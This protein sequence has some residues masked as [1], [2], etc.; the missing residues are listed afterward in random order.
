MRMSMRRLATVSLMAVSALS[1]ETA[2]AGDWARFRG[3][4]GSGVSA[5]EAAIPA[6]WSDSK[7]LQWKAE[8][9]GPGSSSPIVVGDRVFVTSWSG[10]ADNSGDEGSLDSLQRHLVCI[11]RKTGRQLW[12]STV[13]A[14][15][16]EETYR[17][18]FAEN[19]YKIFLSWC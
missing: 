3:P 15:L 16:P 9:P 8:L 2:T 11:D 1:V 10:Y 18:M 7:N 17:G 19:G 5:D 13:D 4:N 14:K 12:M 6:E